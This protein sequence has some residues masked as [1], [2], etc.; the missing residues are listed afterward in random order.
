MI[1]RIPLR[2]FKSSSELIGL[3]M[4]HVWFRFERGVIFLHERGI[5]I[6]HETVRILVEQ[7]WSNVCFGNQGETAQ[8]C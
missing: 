7:I 1:K 6:S 2:Y 3:P 8:A 4:V 5:E